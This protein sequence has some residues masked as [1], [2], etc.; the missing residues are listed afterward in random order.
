[1]TNYEV[2]VIL[3]TYN[4]TKTIERAFQSILEQK[5]QYPFEI[6]IVDDGSKDGTIEVINQCA[7]K[8]HNVTSVKQQNSGLSA[9]RNHGM[10]IAKGKYVMFSDDDD[11]YEPDYLDNV[12]SQMSGNKLVIAGIKKV[13][14]NGN[15]ELENES[16]LKS[17]TSNDNL[18]EKYLVDNKEMDVGAWN[19]LYDLQVIKNNN[20]EFVNKTFFE[21]SLFVLKYLKCINY[22]EI[23]FVEKAEYVIYKRSGSIT[24]S[25]QPQLGKK[26]QKYINDVKEIVSVDGQ[27]PDY[28]NS[29][30]ARIDL[31]FVHRNILMNANWTASEQRKF[32]KPDLRFNYFKFLDKKYSVALG[33]A[34]ILPSFYIKLYKK[35]FA[36]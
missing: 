33:L 31:Y 1:M 25:F 12:M 9:A 26:C 21:D 7:N 4:S 34:G 17:A 19:K 8:Y 20:L 32:L 11:E 15:V 5:T 36:K 2:S 10:Q 29:F 13:L 35:Q 14:Q 6:I 28:F 30:K 23:G 22:D 24:N 16:V 18:I 3:T 27:V